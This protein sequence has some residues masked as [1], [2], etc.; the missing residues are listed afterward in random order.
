[1]ER[2]DFIQNNWSIIIGVLTAVFIA[3]GIVSEFRIL[4][5]EIEELK[6]ETAVKIKA[7]EDERDR[8]SGW[9]QEQEERIDELEEWQAYEKGRQSK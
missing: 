6:R 5:A 8:K 1:M 9:L 7:I 3:G 2:N 4:S